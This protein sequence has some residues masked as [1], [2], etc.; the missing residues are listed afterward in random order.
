MAVGLIQGPL[1]S[2][3][4]FVLIS[5]ALDQHLCTQ[6]KVRGFF[7][8]KDKVVFSF[9]REKGS[10]NTTL[11]ALLLGQSLLMLLC[12][13]ISCS[14]WSL[15]SLTHAHASILLVLRQ[16]NDAWCFP[17]HFNVQGVIKSQ[18]HFR[19]C[20]CSRR[21]KIKPFLPKPTVS[22]GEWHNTLIS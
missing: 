3:Q 11:P 7:P 22:Q 20:V 4:I 8:W 12:I 17:P 14:S 9:H 5:V 2:M 1:K 10:T 21:G 6:M 13:L 15:G 18:E 16:N 19:K